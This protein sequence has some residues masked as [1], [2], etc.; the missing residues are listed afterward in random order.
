MGNDGV[1]A[2]QEESVD[3]VGDSGK[4]LE[5]PSVCWGDKRAVGEDVGAAGGLG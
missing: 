4:C 3:V 2:V 5:E 1:E